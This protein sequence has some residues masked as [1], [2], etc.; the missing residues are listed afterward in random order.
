MKRAVDGLS[1]IAYQAGP[2]DYAKL[3]LGL[4]ALAEMHFAAGAK[5]VV[6]GAHGLPARV[7]KDQLRL[8]DELP[9]DPGSFSLVATHLFGTARMAKTA[10]DGVI[11]LDFETHG[12]KGMWVVDSS[13][14]PS[15]IGVNPMLTI[16]A[17]AMI[18]GEKIARTWRLCESSSCTPAAR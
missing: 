1:Q 12:L 8:I 11:G 4:R 15:N 16:M 7:T 18:A 13:L 14:F 10:A 9:N 5:F 6:V 17:I 2:D 3:R